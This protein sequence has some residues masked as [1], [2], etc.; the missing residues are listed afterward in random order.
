MFHLK[1]V[2]H[3]R[4]PDYRILQSL[5]DHA[6]HQLE[7]LGHNQPEVA[8]RHTQSA[9][10]VEPHSFAAVAERPTEYDQ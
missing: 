5:H 8:V 1:Q 4:L 7:D 6:L 9:V 2:Q 3:N 10:E